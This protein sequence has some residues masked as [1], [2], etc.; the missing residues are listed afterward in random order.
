M[1][2]VTIELRKSHA[3]DQE[4]EII[5]A[6]HA[7]MMEGLKIPSW[8]KNIRLLVHEPHRFAAPP[9]KD[10]RYTLISIDLFAGRSL[11]A[12]KAFYRALAANL[13]PLGIPPDHVKVVLREASRENW[14]IGGVP[15]SE[16]DLGFEV[17][18]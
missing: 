4:T 2:I 18:V 9:G 14:G 15:A 6:V 7:A 12:K 13:Q 3:P 17:N 16:I 5:D 8:D 11:N 1:P 10:E